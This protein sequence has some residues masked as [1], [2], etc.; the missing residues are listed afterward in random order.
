MIPRPL[1]VFPAR[2]QDAKLLLVIDVAAAA[3]EGDSFV[4]DGD[5]VPGYDPRRRDWQVHHLAEI[6]RS[7]SVVPRIGRY[8]VEQSESGTLVLEA[9]E[10]TSE[11]DRRALVWHCQSVMPGPTIALVNALRAFPTTE[12][13]ADAAREVVAQINSGSFKNS[14]LLDTTP[15]VD[16]R[17]VVVEGVACI[18]CGFGSEVLLDA[19]AKRV[20]S[21]RLRS[22]ETGMKTAIEYS[23]GQPV[24]LV[25]YLGH[26]NEFA[27]ILNKELALRL[28]AAIE[29]VALEV[30]T[31]T[32]VKME[33]LARQATMAIS[34]IQATYHIDPAVITSRADALEAEAHAKFAPPVDEEEPNGGDSDDEVDDTGN[35]VT[36][37]PPAPAP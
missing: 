34:A 31:Q 26:G 36:L 29:A 33:T 3:G 37:E 20:L 35:G 18:H 7:S 23:D 22:E 25:G 14:M 32:L 28:K 21:G 15:V 6:F 30:A 12:V 17:E 24:V 16:A 8:V 2:P 10:G 4:F 11:H 13:I 1:F 27:S 5:T 9:P 19:I